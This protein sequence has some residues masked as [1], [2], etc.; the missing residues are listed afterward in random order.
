MHGW[1]ALRLKG[2]GFT[3]IELMVCMVIIVITLLV[4]VPG[5][6]QWQAKRRM[7]AAIHALQQDLLAAR[8]QAILLGAEVVACPGNTNTGCRNDSDWSPG[9][10]VFHDVNGDRE[11]G[12]GEEVMRLTSRQDRVHIR[13]AARR[14]YVRFYPN[15]TAPGSNGSIWFC[16]ELG[17]EH[18]RRL[19]LSNLGR[20]RREDGQGLEPEDCP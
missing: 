16:G 3:V 7:D 8:S 12:P 2:H 9:W 5:F 17:P 11:F 18:A 1:Q 10:I 20:L 19:V 15:G 13:S 14:Q 4:A 6:E